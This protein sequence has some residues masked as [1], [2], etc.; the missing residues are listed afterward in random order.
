M[1]AWKEAAV[2]KWKGEGREGRE[3]FWVSCGCIVARGYITW[4][5]DLK[6]AF[7]YCIRLLP[8]NMV[9]VRLEVR[10]NLRGRLGNSNHHPR[11]LFPSHTTSLSL[12]LNI[13]LPQLDK[14]MPICPQPFSSKLVANYSPFLLICVDFGAPADQFRPISAVK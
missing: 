1:E 12:S 7:T 13:S 5:S 2:L 14:T 10:L 8:R 4:I 9:P 11:A 6:F 3:K